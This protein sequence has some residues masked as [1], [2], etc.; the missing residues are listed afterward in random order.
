MWPRDRE[1]GEPV[2]PRDVLDPEELAEYYA[3]IGKPYWWIKP[4]TGD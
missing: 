1:T 4:K 3:Q 2:D